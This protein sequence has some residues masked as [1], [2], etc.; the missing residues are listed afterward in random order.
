MTMRIIIGYQ[1]TKY[2][3]DDLELTPFLFLVNPSV[4]IIKVYGIGIC[5]L[6]QAIY[7]GLAFNLPKHFKK[8]FFNHT[9]N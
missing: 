7:I 5:W 9:K 8:V 2:N 6:H 1:N 4:E 3:G